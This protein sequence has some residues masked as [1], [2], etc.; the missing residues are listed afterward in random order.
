MNYSINMTNQGR[1]LK[2]NRFRASLPCR[3][4]I[5]K[6]DPEIFAMPNLTCLK[7]QPFVNTG[8]AH[9]K[10]RYENL[11]VIKESCNEG[12]NQCKALLISKKN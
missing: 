1:S 12:K 10:Y 2:Q 3:L 5:K 4:A 8:P 11:F 6:S 9:F 7:L